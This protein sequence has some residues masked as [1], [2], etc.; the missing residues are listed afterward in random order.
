MSGE[1]QEKQVEQRTKCTRGPLALPTVNFTDRY[2]RVPLASPA[3]TVISPSSTT[4]Q[5][6][7]ATCTVIPKLIGTVPSITTPP[8]SPL[9]H[10]ISL[11]LSLSLYIYTKVGRLFLFANHISSLKNRNTKK[12]KQQ[13]HI[14]DSGTLK[15]KRR[16]K[17]L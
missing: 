3:V 1:I 4:K 16:K 6:K 15:K 2:T 11:S 9:T 17:R 12:P 5:P 14:V 8:T 13:T 10:F 7:S